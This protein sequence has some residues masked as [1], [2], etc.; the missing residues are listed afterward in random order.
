MR[1][2]PKRSDGPAGEAHDPHW[3][4]DDGTLAVLRCGLW[5]YN[6]IG[7]MSEGVACAIDPG[8]TPTETAALRT[9]LEVGDTRVTHVVLTHAHHDHIRG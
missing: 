7:L 2:A 5:R 3:L 6:A 4:I 8:I 1:P 9:R